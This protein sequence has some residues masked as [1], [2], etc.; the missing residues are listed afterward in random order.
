MKTQKYGI[1]G[2]VVTTLHK[3]CVIAAA[4]ENTEWTKGEGTR[5]L[6]WNV[7]FFLAVFYA[8]NEASFSW[9]LT[10]V[11]TNLRLA[12]A[13]YLAAHPE[14]N[15]LLKAFTTHCLEKCPENVLEEAVDF[16]TDEN[17]REKVAGGKYTGPSP[18]RQEAT[19]S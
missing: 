13:R 18:E 19:G 8:S 3:H 1:H 10:L 2:G 6:I 4:A 17:L 5:N 14:F 11:Q 15:D 9:L 12:N 16:F 7:F